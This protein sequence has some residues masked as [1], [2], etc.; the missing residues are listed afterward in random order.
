[1]LILLNKKLILQNTVY[2][3]SLPLTINKG[4]YHNKSSMR[5]CI[6]PPLLYAKELI[7]KKSITP[8]YIYD[9]DMR[10]IFTKKIPKHDISP[11]LVKIHFLGTSS[12]MYNRI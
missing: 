9:R 11:H 2:N 4:I 8:R 12:G 1:M 3:T 7:S 5:R 6:Q 10:T